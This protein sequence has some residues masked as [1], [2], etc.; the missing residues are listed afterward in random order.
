MLGPDGP[1]VAAWAL[2]PIIA[3]RIG[4]IIPVQIHPLLLP[5]FSSGVA[6]CI[7]G[8]YG[9]GGGAYWVCWYGSGT[10]YGLLYIV[11]FFLLCS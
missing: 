10:E 3:T 1:D 7:G 8:T 5:F 2:K 6:G 11:L 4:I 9:G